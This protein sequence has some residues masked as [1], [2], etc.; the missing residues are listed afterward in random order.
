LL[1]LQI[2]FKS[3]DWM[4]PIRVSCDQFLVPQSRRLPGKVEICDSGITLCC[5]LRLPWLIALGMSLPSKGEGSP[6]SG[7]LGFMWSSVHV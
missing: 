3:D 2:P 1:L 7:V 6:L 4:G 5:L